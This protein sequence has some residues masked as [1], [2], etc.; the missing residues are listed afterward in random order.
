MNFDEE[1]EKKLKEKIKSSPLTAEELYNELL[2]ASLTEK[3]KP[4]V[5]KTPFKLITFEGKH[6]LVPGFSWDSSTS[7]ILGHLDEEKPKNAL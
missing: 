1:L 4:F 2:R 7:Q 5:Q 3:S 6:G